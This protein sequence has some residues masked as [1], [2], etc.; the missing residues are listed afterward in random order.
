MRGRHQGDVG[1]DTN[2][3]R[4][5]ETM[6]ETTNAYTELQSS[7]RAYERDL[8]L[9]EEMCKDAAEQFHRYKR[10]VGLEA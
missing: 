7:G 4:E 2:T 9:L 6:T 10:E 3:T 5:E 1:D 8:Q